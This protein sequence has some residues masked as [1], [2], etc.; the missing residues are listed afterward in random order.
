MLVIK[1]GKR[2]KLIIDFIFL[3]IWISMLILFIYLTPVVISNRERIR[4]WNYIFGIFITFLFSFTFFWMTYQWI[5]KLISENFKIEFMDDHFNFQSLIIRQ[6]VKYEDIES[7]FVAKMPGYFTRRGR[8]KILKIRS[9]SG[10]RCY[11]CLKIL[12]AK[13]IKEL[14]RILKERTGMKVREK[15]SFW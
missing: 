1:K 13:E 10:K 15:D 4:L 12:N 3:V 8:V 7:V 5:I 14:K 6:T 2:L 11:I 9:K